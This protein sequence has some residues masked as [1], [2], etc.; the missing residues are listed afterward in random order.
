MP[1]DG[2]QSQATKPSKQSQDLHW[3]PSKPP[4]TPKVSSITSLPLTTSTAT[5]AKIPY[6]QPTT[7]TTKH[8]ITF[9]MPSSP[10]YFMG[11]PRT[12]KPKQTTSDSA[13]VSSYSTSS[14]L[15]KTKL[16]KPLFSLDR[17]DEWARKGQENKLPESSGG[18]LNTLM[19][20]HPR[21]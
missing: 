1:P 18:S 9:N 13:S 5:T 19:G 6:Q 4:R 12:P 17:I 10:N 21:A 7:T 16:K 3:I 20:T 15:L 11:T 14:S 2:L 8:L